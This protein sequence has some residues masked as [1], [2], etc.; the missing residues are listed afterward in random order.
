MKSQVLHIVWC[1]ISGEAAGEIWTWSLLGVEAWIDPETQ[2]LVSIIP[3][4]L[5]QYNCRKLHCARGKWSL[6]RD[7]LCTGIARHREN[8]YFDVTSSALPWSCKLDERQDKT[9]RR[10]GAPFLLCTTHANLVPRAFSG[11]V[12]GRETRKGPGNEAGL[13]REKCIYRTYQQVSRLY[14]VSW[15]GLDVQRTWR[16]TIKTA[17][18]S[19]FSAVA[20]DPK[21][22]RPQGRKAYFNNG[23]DV[24]S[25][26]FQLVYHLTHHVFVLVVR[27]QQPHLQLDDKLLHVAILVDA[28]DPMLQLFFRVSRF[29]VN[30]LFQHLLRFGDFVL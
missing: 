10:V 12:V 15:L 20:A 18:N 16:Q 7:E 8:T 5:V 28:S 14:R 13:M 23:S 29:A 27:G 26:L 17:L 2:Y 21:S 11:L 30:P 1:N 25:H 4:K 9:S 3:D 24:K 6:A 22:R 19:S